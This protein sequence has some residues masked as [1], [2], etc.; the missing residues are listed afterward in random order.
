M[1]ED[2]LKHL[3]DAAKIYLELSKAEE[4]WKVVECM[5]N[6]QMRSKEVIHKMVVEILGAFLVS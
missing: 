6:G 4:N 1:H 2:N 3:E 5:E